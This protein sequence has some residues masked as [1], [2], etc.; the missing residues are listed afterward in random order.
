MSGTGEVTGTPD[1][2]TMTFGV[3]VRRDSVSEAVSAA[4]ET[5][6][7]MIEALRTNGVAE[8]DIQTA[9]YSVYPEYDW[10]GE[11]QKLVGYQVN[12]SVV[13]KIRDLDN[14]GKVIDATTKAGGND[15]TVSGVSFSIED[16]EALIEAAREA[17]WKDAEGKAQQLADLAGV[18]LG[19]PT[20][21]NESFSPRPTPFDYRD[22][23]F[24]AED[25]AEFVTPIVPGEQSVAVSLNIQFSIDS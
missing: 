4:A 24:A 21:I 1:T 11:R 23:A 20:M 5:A 14:A 6:D 25:G 19:A 10:T 17:A 15:A 13:A 7:R 2:L 12:N 22:V 8:E 3:S 9:N 18:T 16:N